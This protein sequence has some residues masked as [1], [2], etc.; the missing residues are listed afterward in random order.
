MSVFR[1]NSGLP[2]MG[3]ERVARHRTVTSDAYGKFLPGGG[4]IDGTKS[5]D[6]GEEDGDTNHLRA[7]LLM[8]RI[9][10]SGKYA[11]S[12]FGTTAGALAGNGTTITVSVA[13][14]LEIVRRIGSTGNLTLTGPP[15]ANSTARSVTIPFTAVNT[16]TGVVTVTPIGVNQMERIR[17]NVASTGGQQQLNVQKPDGTFATT[18]NIA[19]S[20]TDATYLASINS[21]LDTTTGVVGGIV[22]TAISATDTDLGFTLTY[23]GTGYAGLPYR[24]AEVIV[25][26]TSSTE[27]IYEPVTTA[28]NGAFAAGSLVGDTDGSQVPVSFITD[29]WGE[30]IVLTAAGLGTDQPWARMPYERLIQDSQL[31]PW[32]SDTGLRT[33]LRNSLRSLGA[34]FS[35]ADPYLA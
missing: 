14:A 27:A 8:G 15:S 7:G 28:A 11:N 10:A 5:R 4:I 20:A 25:L 19:W 17:F 24:R 35:F 16:S 30:L 9:T 26:P 18:A 13:E 12:F 3:T 29:G 2:Q 22:A 33:Y 21:A 23:S 1:P 6:T 34:Q 32:P 31:L